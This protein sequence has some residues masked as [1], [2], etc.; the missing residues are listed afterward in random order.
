MK[1]NKIAI[2]LFLLLGLLAII[3]FLGIR[4]LKTDNLQEVKFEKLKGENI[5]S[6][7]KLQL[8]Y[9]PRYQSSKGHEMLQKYLIDEM[10]QL[11]IEVKT[12]KWEHTSFDGQKYELVNIIG[13]IYPEKENRIILATHYDSKKFAEN[14]KVDKTKPM[15]GANDGAS[16]VAVILEIARALAISKQNIDVGVD[17]IFFDGEEGDENLVNNYKYYKTWGSIYFAEHIDEFY[18][19]KKPISGIVLDMVCDKDLQIFKEQSSVLFAPKQV[20]LFE[21]VAKKNNST[22]FK[23]SVKY[24][25]IDDHNPLNGVG[26]PTMLLIDFDYPYFHTTEDTIDKCSALNLGIV[27][28]TVLDYIYNTK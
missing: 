5:L 16:G 20:D 3:I 15:P 28:N 10:K 24:N 22:V 1:K 8:D 13:Q 18:K 26:I 6:L 21:K 4:L 23:D 25:M 14:D 2:K 11:G 7:I 12:Q 17:V 9:G 19:D 27:A